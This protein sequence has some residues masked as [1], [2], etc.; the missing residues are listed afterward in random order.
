MGHAPRA[1]ASIV[2]AAHNEADRI[3]DCLGTALGSALEGEFEVVVICNG[4][5]DDTADIARGFSGVAVEE[6]P[7]ASKVGALNIGDEVASAFPRL[8]VDADI[9]ISTTSLRTMIAALEGG[10]LLAAGPRVCFDTSG[11]SWLVRMYYSV[12]TRLGWERDTI[13][14][15]G[16]YGVSEVGRRRFERFP[17]LRAEDYWF[18]AQFSPRER[19]RVDAAVSTVD[20]APDVRRLVKRK[21]RVLAYNRA[22]DAELAGAPGRPR[23][24]A[25]GL[26]RLARS[27]PRLIPAIVI[28]AAI[29]LSSDFLARRRIR[30]GDHDWVSDR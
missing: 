24:R 10:E 30:K 13:I 2:I 4:C 8:Y 1:A 3:L 26:S 23:G 18:N 6:T 21:A 22:A 27:Q 28:Y 19:S 5:T 25:G 17:D 9:S 16:V 15:G 20:V 12:W 7:E 14:G 11:A 29:A